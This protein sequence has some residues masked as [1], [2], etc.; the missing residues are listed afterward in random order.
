VPRRVV[1]WARAA[2]VPTVV[3]AR[4]LMMGWSCS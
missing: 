2:L 3:S 4:E 1:R